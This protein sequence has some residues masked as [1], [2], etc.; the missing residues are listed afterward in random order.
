MLVVLDAHL[1]G[2]SSGR[3]DAHPKVPNPHLALAKKRYRGNIRLTVQLSPDSKIDA[4]ILGKGAAAGALKDQEIRKW[5]E[6]I[7]EGRYQVV[8]ANTPFSQGA[9]GDEGD[10][11]DEEDEE[12]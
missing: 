2:P 8:K 9:E 6:D 5:L 3:A 10:Q 12:Q 7:E 4:A 1:S 11:D